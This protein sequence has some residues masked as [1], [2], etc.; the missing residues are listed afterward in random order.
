MDATTARV[1]AAAA[2]LDD[3]RR[4]CKA[5]EAHEAELDIALARLVAAGCGCRGC[6]GCEGCRVM[7]PQQYQNGAQAVLCIGIASGLLFSGVLPVWAGFLLGAV[8][9]FLFVVTAATF[10]DTEAHP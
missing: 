1:L 3:V 5:H 2:A 6:R 8:P 9:T 4:S 10:G 7:S